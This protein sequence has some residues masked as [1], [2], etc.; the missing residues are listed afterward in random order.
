[1]PAARLSNSAGYKF[2][3]VCEGLVPCAVRSSGEQTIRHYWK[4]NI[5]HSIGEQ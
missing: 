4:H 1:M 5:R 3:H 2:E